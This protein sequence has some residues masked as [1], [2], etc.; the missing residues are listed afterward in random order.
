MDNVATDN[1]IIWEGRVR[2][3]DDETALVRLVNALSPSMQKI[4]VMEVFHGYDAMGT[5]IWLPVETLRG[6]HRL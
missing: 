3:N 1:K 6:T 5:G 4:N 2:L